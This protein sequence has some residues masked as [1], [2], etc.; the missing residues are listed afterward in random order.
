MSAGEADIA[1]AL[2][3]VRA[4]ID[5]ACAR[6]GRARGNVRLVAVSKMHGADAVRAAYAAGQR[7]FGENYVQELREKAEALADLVDL[8][9]SFIGHLQRNKAKDVVRV[10]EM[11]ETVDSERLAIELARQAE[12]AS[13]RLPIL[14]EVNIAG[15]AQKSGVAPR[16]V[17]A[18]LTMIRALPSLEVR[19]LMC[20]P[21]A[22]DVA[23]AS[24]PHFRALRE[25]AEA[26]GL[27][28]LSM[29]MTSDFE[30]AIEEGAT[31]I[32]V[33]T[34]IFGAR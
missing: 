15:E 25:L 6:A 31:S 21:P 17:T 29:G 1:R 16:D 27:V 2:H 30:I 14:V 12:A 19:G 18:L 3:G 23:E 7:T 28:E 20:V 10:A 11:V 33:G 34:A 22:S 4:R 26:H 32:R 24:R 9:W 5:A 13:R 8:R